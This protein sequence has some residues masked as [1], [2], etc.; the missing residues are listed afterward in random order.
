MLFRLVVLI[1]FKKIIRW[2]PNDLL[3]SLYKRL[4]FKKLKDFIV[5]RSQYK[6]LAAVLGV[7]TNESG[8]V[9]L[10]KHSYRKEPW[11]IPGGWLELEAPELGLVREIREETGLVAEITGLEKVVYDRRPHRLEMVF[12]GRIVGG[13]FRPSTEITEY[14]FCRVGQWPEGMPEDQKKLVAQITGKR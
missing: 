3:V 4:P 2:I 11:G 7:M 5:Y 8:E 9:L 12:R 6:F 14:C 1:V 13:T 10:L